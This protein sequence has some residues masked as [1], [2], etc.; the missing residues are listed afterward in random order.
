MVRSSARSSWAPGA[1]LLA[2]LSV[3]AVGCPVAAQSSAI[4][5]IHRPG[6]TVRVTTAGGCPTSLGSATDVRNRGPW[7]AKMLM[8]PS[9]SRG[10]ICRYSAYLGAAQRSS[11]AARYRRVRLG[12]AA[13][14]HL[15]R[16]I[17]GID[18]RPPK[19]KFSCPAGFDSATI[20]AFSYGNRPDADLWYSD[21]ACQTLDNGR[22][23]AFEGANPSFYRDFTPLLN[24]LAPPAVDFSRAI[25]PSSTALS[26]PAAG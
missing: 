18:T 9:P 1:T 5:Q 3:I 19:G 7:Q 23:G 8:P 2:A 20:I 10:L 11:T 26:P 21:T 15:A 16:V 25:S 14:R 4:W 6:P 13:A 17:A 24:R 12:R 22:I